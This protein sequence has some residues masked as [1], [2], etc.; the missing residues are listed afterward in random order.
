[1]AKPGSRASTLR[2]APVHSIVLKTIGNAA[3]AADQ[4]ASLVAPVARTPSL[5]R[6]AKVEDSAF[7]C[8]PTLGWLANSWHSNR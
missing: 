5:S 7:V 3:L 4:N 6:L 8:Q 2:S 1:M